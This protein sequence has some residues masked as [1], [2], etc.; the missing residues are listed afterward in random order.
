[1]ISNNYNSFDLIELVVIDTANNR[2]IECLF[3]KDLDEYQ[4]IHHIVYPLAQ[5]KG[6]DIIKLPVYTSAGINLSRFL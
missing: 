4:K 6:F 1:M 2:I 3:C 5:E